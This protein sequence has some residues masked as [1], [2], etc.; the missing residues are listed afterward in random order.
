MTEASAGGEFP[1]PELE[2]EVGARHRSVL[3]ER[4]TELLLPALQ[5]PGSVAVDA[6]L[7]MGGHAAELLR[8]S[9]TTRLVGIDR[10]PQ[11]LELAGRRLA[12][13]G[14]R[15]T[16]VHAVHDALPAVLDGLGLETVD[17]VFFDLGVSSLQLDEVE[18]GFSYSRDAPL[19]MRMDATSTGPT[20]ADVLNTYSHSDLARLLRVYGEERFAPRIASAVLR[21]REREP[22][23]SSARLVDLVRANVP[24]ATRRTGGNPAKRTFQALRIEVN[25]ELRVVER[26]LPAAFERLA[27][28]GRLAVL[29]FHSLEDRIAKTVLRQLS[30]STA[31]PDMPVAPPGT[32]PRAELL[33]RSGE[34]A[35]EAELAENPRSASARLRA[36][37]R[38]PADDR[39][40]GAAASGRI[41]RRAGPP[42]PGRH[43]GSSPAPVHDPPPPD[44]NGTSDGRTRE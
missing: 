28:G 26:A 12:A 11:A 24:A 15:V 40:H 29:T 31:P 18:R 13:F 43:R 25:D 36:V 39:E 23:T 20:A 4:C 22:F 27:V 42:R 14:D 21:E 2:L 38:L 1:D 44:E 8:R 30:T 35:D 34:T 19:D 9:P 16:L 5:H 10:D 37:V 17:A 41:P 6:T 32:G 3:L 33:T 7:G